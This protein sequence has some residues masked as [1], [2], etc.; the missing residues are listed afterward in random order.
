MIKNLVVLFSGFGN[1]GDEAILEGTLTALNSAIEMRKVIILD[2]Y[3][4]A[5]PKVKKLTMMNNCS[6][7]SLASLLGN[8]LGRVFKYSGSLIELLSD[9]KS[10][11]S[12]PKFSGILW[13]KGG[14]GYDEYHGTKGLLMSSSTTLA[15]RKMFSFGVLGGL[16]LGFTRTQIGKEV[17]SRF[18][19]N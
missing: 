16:S 6:Y 11:K 18:L 5:P 19:R 1:L 13:H 7:T 2:G 14:S 15:I 9:V 17:L 12:K 10:Q 8:R 4:D 3:P